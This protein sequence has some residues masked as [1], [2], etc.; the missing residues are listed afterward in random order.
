MGRL[1]GSI[2]RAL[3]RARV[4]TSADGDDSGSTHEY[5]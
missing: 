5:H 4:S 3:E 2:E 1:N